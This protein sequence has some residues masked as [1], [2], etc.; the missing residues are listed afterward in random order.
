[1]SRNSIKKE[2]TGKDAIAFYAD[3]EKIGIR[4]W[5]NGGW[6]VDALIGKQTRPH[7][8]LDIIIE[9]KD[10]NRMRLLMEKQGYIDI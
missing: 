7:S 6:G 10:L 8:D 3:L 1:V 9:K 4:I 2:M 5:I